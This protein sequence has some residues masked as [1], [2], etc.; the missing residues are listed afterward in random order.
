[1]KI[2]YVIHQFYPENYTG[3]EKFLLGLAKSMQRLGHRVKVITY[4]RLAEQPFAETVGQLQRRSYLY[5][6]VPVTAI[7]YVKTRDDINLCFNNVEMESFAQHV[8][9]EERPDLVHVA[10][11]MRVGEFATVA[12][13]LGL[14]YVYTLTDFF[15]ICPKCQLITSNNSLCAGPQQGEACRRFCPELPPDLITERLKLSAELLQQAARIFSP[16]KFLAA[17]FKSQWPN[18]D[19]QVNPHGL[20]TGNLKR[21]TRPS[22]P[23]DELTFF[24]GGSFTYHKGV[25]ILIDAFRKVAGRAKLKLYGSGPLEETLLKLANGDD[26]IEFCGVFAADQVSTVLQSVDIAIVPSIWYENAPFMIQEALASQVPVVATDAGG[27]A[28]KIRPGFNGFTFRIGDSDSLKEV[29]QKL[30]KQ[31]ELLNE[32]KANIRTQGVQTVE[33]EALAYEREYL[34]ILEKG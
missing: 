11:S 32:L 15:L 20:S 28:E 1:M 5:Q 14:P 21:N 31:P 9:A 12:H 29:L 16:S 13:N 30:V 33:Q 7:E 24:Y 23:Q 3:T 26:R 17:M 2:L 4:L 27:M 6:G 18:L 10:H 22:A 34:Q 8:L 25:H 19:I